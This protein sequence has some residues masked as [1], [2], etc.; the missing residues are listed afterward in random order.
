MTVGTY[1]SMKNNMLATR[2]YRLDGSTPVDWELQSYAAALDPLREELET[3]QAESFAATACDYGL[4][5]A[6]TA[7]GVLWPAQ[8]V[9]DRRKTV[10][11]LGAVGTDGFGRDA[12]RK[13]LS[14]LGITADLSE[15]AANR[16]LTIRVKNEP[17]GGTSVWEQIV[18]RFV[19]AHL[20]VL[21]DYSGM[22]DTQ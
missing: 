1:D 16:K 14:D 15:D 8:T 20:Q 11:T 7:L 2:L 17:G 10:C 21:W 13:L 3:L 6:E 19:S 9:E 12:F 22:A 4:R 18:G 5:F